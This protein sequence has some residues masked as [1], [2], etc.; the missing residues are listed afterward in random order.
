M[1]E[2]QDPR[3]PYFWLSID[4]C[5]ATVKSGTELDDL[6]LADQRFEAGNYFDTR[7][8]AMLY[9]DMINL[10]IQI[11]TFGLEGRAPKVTRAAKGEPFYYGVVPAKLTPPAK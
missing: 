2:K 1:L 11:R 8:G 9:A 6:R 10:T 3:A 4:T 7:R 5:G